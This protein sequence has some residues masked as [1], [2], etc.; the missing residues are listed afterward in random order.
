MPE[1]N[2][3]VLPGKIPEEK[4]PSETK[5]DIRLVLLPFS[6]LQNLFLPETFA[7]FR[8][9]GVAIL[10]QSV[11]VSRISDINIG[12][13]SEILFLHCRNM[14]IRK[15]LHSQSLNGAGASDDFLRQY[16]RDSQY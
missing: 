9:E 13:G 1:S 2:L 15:K 6:V 11:A 8:Q 10:I 3:T 5:N 14:S 4:C 16:H 7:V 12:I